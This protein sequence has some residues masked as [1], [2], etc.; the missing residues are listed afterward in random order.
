MKIVCLDRSTI[1]ESINFKGIEDQAENITYHDFT[2]SDKVI[3]RCKYA[4]V[5]ITN[6]VV[7]T[8]AQLEQLP[9][10]K[11]ICIAA[12]GTNN[13]DIEAATALGIKVCNVKSYS[14]PSVAQYVFSMLLEHMQKS[15]HYIANTRQNHWQNS[16]IFCHFS[17][18]IN[19]LS[20]KVIS[21]VGYGEIAKAV[22]RI[23][24]AFG[25]KVLIAERQGA[26]NIRPERVSFEQAL[27]LA[28][29]VTLHSP[30]TAETAGLIN[31]QTLALMKPTA[32]LINTARGGL[33]NSKDL[34]SSIKAKQ[35]GAAILDVLEQEPPPQDHILLNTVQDNLYITA[36]IAW[37]SLEAQQRLV[38]GIAN[39]IAS[40]LNGERLNQLN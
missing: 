27:Q 39:N 10:L 6:K 18:P 17:L 8:K 15:A 31:K 5:I 32:I 19:E 1:D 9:R 26:T 37:G 35:L 4:E 16:P 11:L 3:F 34:L 29:V 2:P 21:I 40:F 14:T 20:N 7:L 38:D 36:H 28:D 23:A 33:V 30:L 25:M 13:V 22:E 12:T 24:H